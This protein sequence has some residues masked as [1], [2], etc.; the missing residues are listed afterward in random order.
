MP[1]NYDHC[2]WFV[3]IDSELETS[4]GKPIKLLEFNYD[5]SVR[6]NLKLGKTF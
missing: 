1:W 3:E 6:G 4:D 5:L 2:N